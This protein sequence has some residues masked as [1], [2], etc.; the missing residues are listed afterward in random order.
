MAKTSALFHVKLDFDFDLLLA[1]ASNI[2]LETFNLIESL[3][4]VYLYILD[5]AFEIDY[6]MGIVF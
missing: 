4:I 2:A 1:C 6:K 3:L 5:L